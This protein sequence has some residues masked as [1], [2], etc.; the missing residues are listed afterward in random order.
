[1][2]ILLVGNHNTKIGSFGNHN[3]KIGPFGP[4][5]VRVLESERSGN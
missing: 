1:M 2:H 3:T 5:E 4:S